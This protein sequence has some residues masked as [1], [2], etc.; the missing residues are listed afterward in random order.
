M[1]EATTEPQSLLQ[2]FI[3]RQKENVFSRAFGFSSAQLPVVA[4]YGNHLAQRVVV[5]DDIGFVYHVA[6][7]E[8]K[9]PV[10][11]A[12]LEKWIANQVVR[13]GVKQIQNT[14]D[15][16]R[17]YIS[18]SVTNDF[19][20]RV[21]VNPRLAGEMVCAII[22]RLPAKSRAFRAARFK[23]GRNGGFIHVL[24][25]VDYFE[26]C[27]HFV[28]PTELHA[29]FSFRRDVLLTW[30][31]PAAAVTEGAL[32]GQFLLGDY[33]SP[34]DAKFA[35]A[36]LSH[37]GPTACEFAFVLDTL[38]SDIASQESDYGDTDNYNIL[39]ELG[40]TG[41]RE[42]TALKQHIR[43]TL[44]TVRSDRFELPYR[45]M[46]PM[47]SC[48]FLLLP[49]NSQFRTR[50]FDAL[51][52]LCMA[53]KHELKV[54]KQIGIGMWQTREFVDIEWMYL[55]G[56]HVPNPGLDRRLEH[57]YPFRLTSEKRLPPIFL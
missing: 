21:S 56:A 26:I 18:L 47:R 45:V 12:D 54:Q 23:A 14:V 28:T 5:L 17:N 44:D 15:L 20:H 49:V 38:G 31:P 4:E 51:A 57:M 10:K 50:A 8:H 6:E 27:S 43:S 42:L 37:G 7:R 13:K 25:D 2:D 11:T 24:R 3:A 35:P 33:L 32:I 55:D 36:A 40:R 48:A 41:R 1:N 30:D 39:V 22:Y 9:G 19:G 46:S 16:L 29:Y 52:S 34:P 53:S